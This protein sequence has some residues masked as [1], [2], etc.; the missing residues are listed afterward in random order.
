[1]KVGEFDWKHANVGQGAVSAVLHALKYL[2]I[3]LI[4]VSVGLM[5]LARDDG[6]ARFRSVL[7]EMQFLVL[8]FGLVL[9]MLGFFRGA[10]PKGSYSRLTFGMSVAV[11]AIIYVFML[12]LGGG[13]QEAIAHD[14]FDLDLKLIF[15]LYFVSAMFTVFMQ[16][17]EFVDHRHPWLEGSAQIAAQEKE[18]PAQHRWFHD[19]RL[20]YG[21]LFNGLKLSRSTLVG[22]VLLPL[23]FII[24]LRGALSSLGSEEVDAMLSSLDEVAAFMLLLGLPLTALAFPKGFYPKGS[25]SRFLPAMAMVLISLYWI[26]VLGMEGK[27]ALDVMEEVSINLDYSALLLLIMAGTA[28]WFVYYVLELWLYRPEWKEGGFRKDIDKKWRKKREE[29]KDE[30]LK[31]EPEQPALVA[32]DTGKGAAEAEQVVP[33]IV[34]EGAAT[35]QPSLVAED[36]GKVTAET[37]QPVQVKEEN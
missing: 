20:R 1:M 5:L 33:A 7:Q 23:I 32:E 18:D 21:S 29:V 37:E 36:T 27:F 12:L 16:L 26:W 31:E 4:L 9:T 14:L 24:I 34:N 35:E 3:L 11:L 22:F 6:P 30:A 15:T 2:V 17:G 28:L 25:F 13:L 8:V 19:F 10:Y